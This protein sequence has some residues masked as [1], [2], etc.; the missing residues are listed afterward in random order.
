MKI[1]A[2]RGRNLAS[3]AREFVVDL[4]AGPLAGV[5]LFAITGPVGAGKSTLLDAL[6]L[7]LF[8][9]TP[10][11]QGRGGALV[12]DGKDPADWL[13]STDPRTLLR[14]DA[15]EGHAEV[16]FVARDGRRY[17]ARWSVRRARRRAD[18]RVQEQELLLRDLERDVV[19]AAGRRSDVLAAVQ[20]LLGLDF[21][22]FCR[23]VLL[24]QGDFAAFVKAPPSERA[25]L[26]ETLTGAEVYRHLS[27]AA[28]ERAKAAAAEVERVRSQFEVQAPLDDDARTRLQTEVVRCASQLAI[29]RVGIRIANQYLQWHLRAEQ[30]RQRES[31][32]TIALQQAQAADV[33]ALPR[34]LELQRRQRALAVV[35]HWE[36]A[37]EAAQAEAAADVARQH[38]TRHVA[39]TEAAVAAAQQ[40][41]ERALVAAFGV[42]PPEP[43]SPLVR[44]PEAWLGSLQQAHAQLAARG[45][46][47]A[48]LPALQAALQAQQERVAVAEAAAT[49]GTATVAAA[50]QAVAAAQAAID[51]DAA[52]RLTARRAE[53]ERRRQTVRAVQDA[54][55]GWRAAEASLAN[56]QHAASEAAAV[57]ADRQQRLA[58]VTTRQ[59]EF[60]A[61]LAQ[62]RQQMAPL[63]QR[64]QAAQLRAHLHDGEPCPL[65]GSLQHPAPAASDDDELA[66]AQRALAAAE[67]VLAAQE[68]EV[69]DGD[70]A[71]R[72][73]RQERER[74]IAAT[75]NAARDLAAAGVPATRALAM[76]IEPAAA[77]PPTDAAAAAAIVSG[78]ERD[79]AEQER[80][81]Q[82]AEA[83]LAQ[84][85]T[86]L[87]RALAALDAA[88]PAAREQQRAVAAKTKELEAARGQLATVQQALDVA[89]ARFADAAAALAPAVA[90]LP[91]GLDGVLAAGIAI[92]PLLAALPKA[93]DSLAA[94]TRDAAAAAAE[95]AR[96]V[97]RAG[98]AARAAAQQSGALARALRANDVALDAVAV[99]ARLGA[100]GLAAEAR[101]L[102]A[103]ADAVTQARAALVA[104]AAERQRHEAEGRPTLDAEDAQRALDEAQQA[105]QRT[106][107]RLRELRVQQDAD[108]LVRRQRA[109]L[110]PRLAAAEAAS[111]TWQALDELIGS[112]TGDAFAVFAQGLTLDLLLVEA[113][114]RLAELARRYRLERQAGGELEFVVVDLDLGGARRS[115]QTLSG[116]ETF[117][118]SLA[119]ALALATLAAPRSRVETLF[120]DEG[121]GTLD[122]H[123]LEVALGALDSL[124]ASGCQVGIISHVEGIAERIGAQ[125][126]VVPEG[127]G[128]SRV[129][130]RER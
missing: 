39:A 14:R 89:A 111:A 44:E 67:R 87:Q 33:A 117:L 41:W 128:Q 130:A 29:D 83:E 11:L 79:F 100:D 68:R 75:A 65:C 53:L 21:D 64:A 18:G 92:L 115:L 81:L 76:A 13:R 60:V 102:Q 112:S 113:N 25:K 124:Q 125:V 121:F 37:Q 31:E 3:L 20:R 80:R 129:V 49:T 119:L 110:Q 107:H 77:E 91:G 52:L 26:L 24:A 72:A 63:A 23:S 38:S 85:T 69:A 62:R 84:R 10:R 61:A 32:A 40:G 48:Q 82:Q 47:A 118:I 57:L 98:A 9:R 96:A 86:V 94:A 105:E 12:G 109:E 66:I 30:Q 97:E 127:A 27:R 5:G 99:A 35:A 90:G 7:P 114:R 126:A 101:E 71:C 106:D 34:R 51:L 50:R 104:I 22:Q 36:L 78:L 93:R 8:D 15:A 108:E 56:L 46:A 1:L 123:S 6:C 45:K 116:G 28:H 103:I 88:E 120:L 58:A 54:V 59:A 122:A 43:W 95:H 73:A 70:L 55:A 16:D 42:V 2:I 19:L 4:A 17:R 74:L